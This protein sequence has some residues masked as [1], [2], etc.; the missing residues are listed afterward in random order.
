MQRH[1]LLVRVTTERREV[2]IQYQVWIKR[3][4]AANIVHFHFLCMW[5]CEAKCQEVPEAVRVHMQAADDTLAASSKRSHLC[6]LLSW[7]ELP[8][9]PAHRK[10]ALELAYFQCILI[11]ALTFRVRNNL[12]S[13]IKKS[14]FCIFL[15]KFPFRS[16]SSLK[17]WLHFIANTKS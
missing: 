10:H 11:A 2:Y 6:G 14:D 16:Y 3:R 9:R 1:F 4:A 13:F 8:M 5:P 7:E 17:Y 12:R 15:Q